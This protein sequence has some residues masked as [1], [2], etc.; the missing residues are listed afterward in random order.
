[1]ESGIGLGEF[2]T[3]QVFSD[4][5]KVR[6]SKVIKDFNELYYRMQRQTWGIT[7][8]RGVHALKTPTDMWVYQEL[9]QAIKPDLIIETGT[10]CGGSALFM[11]DVL[12]K[13]NP[14]GYII[15]I[16]TEHIAS[17]GIL[18]LKDEARV[19]GIDFYLGSSVV[20]KTVD[21]LK[22]YIQEY[23]CQRVMVILDSDHSEEHVLKE[24]EIYSSIVTVGSILIVE[25]TSNHEGARE[26][27]RKWYENNQHWYK[28]NVLCE[29]FML[30]FN[31]DGFFEREG[32]S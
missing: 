29:K 12:D 13:V 30:T 6:F 28:K 14:S 24:L 8:W 7:M 17:D 22:S 19:C 16:D 1:M 20:Q 18:I 27:A 25:D 9:I 32:G 15:S 2:I 21:Y 5:E 11:R 31:R 4:E 23:E 3:H 26:A 10:Y